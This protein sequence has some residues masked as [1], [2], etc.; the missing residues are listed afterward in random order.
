MYYV[1]D[2]SDLEVGF[3][4]RTKVKN[5]IVLGRNV[6]SVMLV[7]LRA[8][9]FYVVKI[10]VTV[11]GICFLFNIEIFYIGEGKIFVCKDR[12]FMI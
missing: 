5:I 1:Y 10:V 6:K 8:C 7:G 11:F 3:D 9:E 2:S 12:W 4:L